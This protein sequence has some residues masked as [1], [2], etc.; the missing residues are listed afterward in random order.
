MFAV[1]P[2]GNAPV[3][4]KATAVPFAGAVATVTT[5]GVAIVI[6]AVCVATVSD[7]AQFCVENWLLAVTNAQ[8]A[9]A[10]VVVPAGAVMPR[11]T[12]VN[13]KLPVPTAVMFTAAP[14]TLV[15]SLIVCPPEYVPLIVVEAAV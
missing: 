9:K 15:D 2:V 10:L 1:I 7:A 14:P 12:G 5:A 13:V 6:V 11:D 4:E 3:V 8:V